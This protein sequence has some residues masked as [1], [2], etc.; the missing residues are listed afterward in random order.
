MLNLC[1]TDKKRMAEK[2]GL[3][4]HVVKLLENGKEESPAHEKIGE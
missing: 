3:H 1:M 4:I 2:E